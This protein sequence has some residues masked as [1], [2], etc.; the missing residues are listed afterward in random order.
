M[1]PVSVVLCP[2]RPGSDSR[3]VILFFPNGEE[4]REEGSVEDAERL[5]HEAG[6]LPISV[7]PDHRVLGT[8]TR[9]LQQPVV[10]RYRRQTNGCHTGGVPEAGL[11]RGSDSRL[12]P[13]PSFLKKLLML[14]I[15]SP[16][17]GQCPGLLTFS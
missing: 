10:G 4:R 9:S 16:G 1:R 5:A 12:F 11:T 15:L 6:L 14:L 17:N 2:P 3:V 7:V 8:G 13:Q